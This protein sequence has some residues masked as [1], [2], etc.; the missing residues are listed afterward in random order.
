MDWET[1]C[2]STF[3][4][5]FFQVFLM[6]HSRNRNQKTVAKLRLLHMSLHNIVLLAHGHRFRNTFI[7]SGHLEPNMGDVQEE[8]YEVP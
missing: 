5:A 1:A 7:R 3:W 2:L 6:R 4:P 8:T